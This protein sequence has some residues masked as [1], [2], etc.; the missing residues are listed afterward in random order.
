MNTKLEELKATASKLFGVPID[1]V[2]SAQ[3]QHAKRLNFCLNY[4]TS[5]PITPITLEEKD[6][7]SRLQ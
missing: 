7:V 2:T 4:S 1:E 6:N 3:R 5:L